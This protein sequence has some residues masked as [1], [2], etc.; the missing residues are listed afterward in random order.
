MYTLNYL[1]DFDRT[2]GRFRGDVPPPPPTPPLLT[3]RNWLE[4]NTAV[5]SEAAA[6]L[7]PEN[8]AAWRDLGEA[9]TIFLDSTPPPPP[10]P[11]GPG[12]ICIRVAQFPGTTA[13][14]AGAKL[15]LAVTFGHPA[16]ARQRQ[17]SPFTLNPAGHN[18]STFVFPPTE[19]NS[20]PAGAKVAWFFPLGRIVNFAQPGQRH[21]DSY[22]F[23]VGVSILDAAGVVI[24]TYSDDPEMD[25]GA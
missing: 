21:N 4:L 8:P 5:L 22:E 12:N 24:R 7:N 10:P 20:G 16:R 13:L 11:G 23:T 19:M 1:I 25:V 9:N 6:L 2:D 15:Q 14:P 18:N 3:S 17:A